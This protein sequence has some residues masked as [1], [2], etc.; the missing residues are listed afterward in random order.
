[1]VDQA[2]FWPTVALRYAALAACAGWAFAH[3]VR[4]QDEPALQAY[5]TG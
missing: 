4:K 1:V 5:K 3:T 2:V